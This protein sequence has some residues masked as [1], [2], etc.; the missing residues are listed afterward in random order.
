[1]TVLTFTTGLV[2]VFNID[3]GALAYSLLIGDLRLTDIGF[4]LELTEHTVDNDLK[5]KLTHTCDNGLSG[6]FVSIEFEGRIFFSQLRKGNTHLFLAC[7]CLRLDSNTDNRIWEVH[8]F[9]YDRMLFVAECVTGG[10]IFKTDRGC[11]IT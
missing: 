4:D 3:I 2:G 9:E 10:G 11:D 7:L 1:M 5:V 6:L 8:R